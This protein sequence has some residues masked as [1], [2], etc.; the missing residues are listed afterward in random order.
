MENISPRS[1]QQ[2]C[3]TIQ[4]PSRFPEIVE[5]SADPLHNAPLYTDATLD[6]VREYLM[7]LAEDQ[8]LQAMLQRT[9]CT[10]QGLEE[11]LREEERRSRALQF[12]RT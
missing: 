3:A 1:T 5:S 9:L 8:V 11:A 7:T 4:R 10:V 6:T 2:E 12:E